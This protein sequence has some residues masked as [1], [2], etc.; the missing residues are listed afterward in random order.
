MAHNEATAKKHYL[1]S[2]KS[3][4]SVEV[5]KKL[6]QLMRTDDGSANNPCESSAKQE[7]PAVVEKRKCDESEPSQSSESKKSQR[8]TWT[9]DEVAKIKRVF[10][11]A[12]ESNNIT[13]D[14]VKTHEGLRPMSP[15]RIYD[16]L[17]KD[18]QSDL[19]A[20]VP[21][22]GP[23]QELDSQTWLGTKR[24]ITFHRVKSATISIP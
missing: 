16:K 15:R 6:G 14:G 12:I 23:P 17:K 13:L 24:T 9:D 19:N 1:L 22:G 3:K 7:T 20:L 21:V 11:D 18:C 5:S 10:K 8:K 4:T 2:E